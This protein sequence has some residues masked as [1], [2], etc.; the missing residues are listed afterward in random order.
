[1]AK[2]EF[3]KAKEITIE[4]K[5]AVLQRQHNR[6]LASDKYLTLETA[7]FH[8]YV[9]R[10]QSGLGY[11]WNIVAITREEHTNL[12]S[13]NKVGRYKNKDF[14]VY[15]H[16]YLLKMYK[17]WTRDNCKYKK[18]YAEKDYGVERRLDKWN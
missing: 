6:S 11:E 10:G 8:H 17:H 1:M 9:E 13:G 18:W 12:H 3:L 4:T 5:K 7:D 16:N 2:S 15:M 14:E